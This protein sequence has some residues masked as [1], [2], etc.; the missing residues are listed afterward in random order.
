MDLANNYD[1]ITLDITMPGMGGIET[2]AK[3]F[4]NNPNKKV[5]M[6]TAMGQEDMVRQAIQAGIRHYLLKPFS[7][8]KLIETIN[9]VLALKLFVS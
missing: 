7:P 3:I 2:A 5:I 4:A 8:P 1:V 9:Q 6:V